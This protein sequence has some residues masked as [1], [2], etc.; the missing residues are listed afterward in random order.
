VIPF[1]DEA[2]VERLLPPVDAVDA[3]ERALLAGLDPEADPPR[4]IVEA[5]QGQLLLMPS[6]AAGPVGVKL[7]TIAPANPDRGLPRIQG[8]YALFDP[9]TLAPVAL[10]DAIALTSLRTAAVSAL[11][12]RH[13][14]LPEASRLLVFGTGPQGWAHVLA[15]RD[16]RPIRSVRV[17]ARDRGRLDAFLHRCRSVGIEAELADASTAAVEEADVIC[18]CTTACEPLFDGSLVAEGA[19]VVAVGSHEASARELD[20]ELLGRSTVIVEAVSPALREAGDVIQAVDSGAL[21]P[22]SLLTLPTLVR[23]EATPAP[24][25]PRVFKSTGMA[26]EDAVVAAALAERAGAGRP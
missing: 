13:L 23:G 12:V 6:T 14:A 16:V 21:S 17:C 10:V 24:D 5:P 26:W 7:A 1:L 18:C 20:A 15:V 9:D 19:C 11:A 3:L 25:R 22:D 4:S 2:D 8:V